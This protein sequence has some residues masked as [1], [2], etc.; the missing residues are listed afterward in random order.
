MKRE[1]DELLEN[2]KRKAIQSIENL[3]FS[4]PGISEINPRKQLESKAKVKDQGIC[5][6]CEISM[7]PSLKITVH[8]LHVTDQDNVLDICCQ[9]CNKVF[10]WFE[11]LSGKQEMH[12]LC[13]NILDHL[14]HKI[15][16][17]SDLHLPPQPLYV[18]TN[19]Y[20][21]IRS[22]VVISIKHYIL[23]LHLPTGY[24]I[25]FCMK[26][27]R[28]PEDFAELELD[29]LHTG[30][31]HQLVCRDFIT[32]ADNFRFGALEA[33]IKANKWDEAQTRLYLDGII[34]VSFQKKPLFENMILIGRPRDTPKIQ[35]DS[36]K[37]LVEGWKYWNIEKN[38]YVIPGDTVVYQNVADM[39]SAHK[40]LTKPIKS[41][42]T[43]HFP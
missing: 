35:Q 25:P 37:W 2:C 33:I 38:G 26:T 10:E 14:Y 21:R 43:V 23:G 16:D 32:I 6:R 8:H 15:M 20:E 12:N 41:V 5:P 30:D 13:D 18:D 29:H 3:E 7:D 39:F 17:L 34:D 22:E 4:F 11:N 28:S 31:L 9:Y 40:K 42:Q 24:H 27:I 1:P 36:G 19:G